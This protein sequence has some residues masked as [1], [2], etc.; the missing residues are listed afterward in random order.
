M[1]TEIGLQFFPEPINEPVFLDC[2]SVVRDQGLRFF[3]LDLY[4]GHS[5]L[6]IPISAAAQIEFPKAKPLNR[7]HSVSKISAPCPRE[8]EHHRELQRAGLAIPPPG[9]RVVR[10]TGGT[11][12]N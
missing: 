6:R 9:A 4:L 10:E 2:G 3:E 1:E 11:F 7:S 8:R 12:V 5:R